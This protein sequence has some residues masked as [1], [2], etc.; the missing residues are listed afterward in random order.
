MPSTGVGARSTSYQNIMPLEPF[1]FAL[2]LEGR[3]R[4]VHKVDWCV[5]ASTGGC[6][7]VLHASIWGKISRC[8]FLRL[9]ILWFQDSSTAQNKALLT[10]IIDKVERH[11]FFGIQVTLAMSELSFPVVDQILLQFWSLK[12][13]FLKM[14]KACLLIRMRVNDAR[15]LFVFFCKL[16]TLFLVQILVSTSDWRLWRSR[17]ATWWFCR[18]QMSPLIWTFC[19]GYISC[20]C[21]CIWWQRRRSRPAICIFFKLQ[22]SLSFYKSLYLTATRTVEAADLLKTAHLAVNKVW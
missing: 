9:C 12:T 13:F 20:I 15:G 22:I 8:F 11:S 10:K 7:V 2:K 17:M 19:S 21:C 5:H 1:W 14:Q 18:K 4:S 16:K 6:F 3:V